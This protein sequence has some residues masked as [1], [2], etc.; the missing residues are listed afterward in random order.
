MTDGVDQPG[1]AAPCGRDPVK[2]RLCLGQWYARR[3]AYTFH[4]L[5]PFPFS[6]LSCNC[7]FPCLLQYLLVVLVYMASVVQ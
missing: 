7:K 4:L 6:E 5:L 2:P 3:P 1:R